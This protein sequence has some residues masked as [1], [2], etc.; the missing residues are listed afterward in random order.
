MNFKKIADTSFK[1]YD[2]IK[3]PNKNLITH[4]VSYLEK[5]KRYHVETL[6]IDTVLNKEHFHG[7]IMQKICTKH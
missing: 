6:A 5:E 7:K 4:Y 3:C 1:V 2:V